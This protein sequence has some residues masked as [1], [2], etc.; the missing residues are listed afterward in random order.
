MAS[1]SAPYLSTMRTVAATVDDILGSIAAG[2]V[3]QLYVLSGDEFLCREASQSLVSAL[4]PDG[5][6]A[7]NLVTLNAPTEREL[8]TEF[9]TTSLFGGRKVVLALDVEFLAPTKARNAPLARIRSAWEAN[10]RKEATRRLLSFIATAGFGLEELNPGSSRFPSAAQWSEKLG[11]DVAAERDLFANVYTFAIEEKMTAPGSDEGALARLLDEG[12]SENV[13]VAVTSEFDAKGTWAKR[14]AD[15]VVVFEAARRFKDLDVAD[16]AQTHLALYDKKLGRGA[17]EELTERVGGNYRALAGELKKLALHAKS[18]VI[19]KEDVTLLVAHDREDE[20]FELADAIQKRDLRAGLK[21]LADAQGRGTEP[22][23]LLGSIASIVRGLVAAQAH[24]P[25]GGAPKNFQD[26]QAKV[27]P[28]IAQS[29]G[30]KPPHPYAAFVAM[31]A[32]GRFKRG[33]LTQALAACAEGDLALKFGGTA[34]VL[35]RLLWSLCGGMPVWKSTMHLV[36]PE[37]ER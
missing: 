30:S 36:R 19:S 11:V 5:V 14:A 10:R 8:A 32:A 31:Q 27:Y 17:L 12:G 22:L 34:L 24:L 20:Y 33:E 4:L 28:R 2:K 29:A 6:T 21:Y 15:G 26:F 37:Q 18:N 35:E 25:A 13:L 9:A 23:M 1:R 3:R 7:F 16:F